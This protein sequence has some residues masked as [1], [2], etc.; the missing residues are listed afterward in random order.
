[1]SRRR[2]VID[3]VG[4]TEIGKTTAL[5]EMIDNYDGGM[6]TIL[7]VQHERALAKYPE[8]PAGYMTR[9]TT[10]IYRVT[11]CDFK[12]FVDNCHL[13]YNKDSEKRGLVCFDDAS[14]YINSA[15]YQ[16]FLKLMQ[17]VRHTGLDII[18]LFHQLWRIPPYIVDNTQVMI[19]KKT[20]ETPDKGDVKRFRHGDRLLD[21]FALVESDEDMYYT[22]VV[23]L[24]GV[25]V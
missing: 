17:G 6:V 7:D 23:D 18:M 12:T 24:T 5:I 10:G 14:G 8:M 20:G 16:P 11:D 2:K 25:K 1:M 15:V 3:I 4:E 19:L 21:A 13:M 22:Q 9:Q